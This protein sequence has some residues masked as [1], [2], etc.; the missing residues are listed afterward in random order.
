MKKSFILYI[1]ILI[2]LFIL[3]LNSDLAQSWNLDLPQLKKEF[4]PDSAKKIIIDGD[5]IIVLRGPAYPE[6]PIELSI[7]QRKD[8]FLIEAKKGN[9]AGVVYSGGP[10]PGALV[11]VR[12]L[13]GEWEKVIEFKKVRG[14]TR[15][16]TQK[17]REKMVYTDSSGRYFFSGIEPGEYEMYARGEGGLYKTETSEWHY[18]YKMTKAKGIK[19]APD[20]TTIVNFGIV[21]GLLLVEPPLIEHEDVIIVCD[22]SCFFGKKFDEILYAQPVTKDP[23]YKTGNIAGIAGGENVKR[24]YVYIPYTGLTGVKSATTDS[25]GRYFIEGLKPG[26]YEI[27]AEGTMGGRNIEVIATYT[28]IVNFSVEPYLGTAFKSGIIPY[29]IIWNGVMI[30]CNNKCFFKKSPEEIIKL[31]TKHLNKKPREGRK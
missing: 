6:G 13:S 3:S 29:P 21:P 5:T 24:I 9:M 25:L 17:T 22:S 11:G 10:L 26:I 1:L 16:I 31:E 7:E 8:T 15:S 30:K 2:I 18:D 4:V 28:T 14:E 20:S 19:V 27:D 23:R 12:R